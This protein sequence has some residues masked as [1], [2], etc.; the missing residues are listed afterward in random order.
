LTAQRLVISWQNNLNR[1]DTFRAVVVNRALHG[2]NPGVDSSLANAAMASARISLTNAIDFEQVQYNQLSQWMGVPAQDF[3]LDTLF[4]SRPPEGMAEILSPN[5]VNHPV[6][7]WY[8]SQITLSDEQTRYY[9]TMNY[10]TFSLVGALQT[11]GSGFS[12][13]YT[14]NPS[15]YSKNYSDGVDPYRSNYIIGIG[16]TWDLTQPLRISQQVKSQRFTTEGLKDLYELAQQQVEAERQL[17]RTK[18]QNALD[19]YFQAPIQVKAAS[20]A[21]LQTTVQYKNG[22][23][24]LVQVTQAAYALVTAETDRDIAY[25]NVWQAL[26]LQTAASGDFNVFINKIKTAP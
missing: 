17:S 1:A 8:K 25:S 21:Y 19:N 2:L 26:L 9:R 20:D 11:R 10:P 5:P 15:H 13:D 7:Q 16:V 23:T 12:Y 18:I 14:L 6:L 24:T 4:I 3:I 22:L